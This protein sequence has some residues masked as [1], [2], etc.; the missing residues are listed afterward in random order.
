MDERLERDLRVGLA[1]I[2]DPV[3]ESHPRWATSPAAERVLGVPAHRGLAGRFGLLWAAV[4]AGLLLVALLAAAFVGGWRPDLAIV[5]APSPLPATVT[6]VIDKAADVLATTKARPLPAQATCPPGSNPD[7]LGS[8]DQDR[9][10]GGAMAFD[11]HAGRIVVYDGSQTWTYDVCTNTWKRMGAAGGPVLAED[12]PLVYDADSDRVLAFGRDQQGSL[13]APSAA[14]SVAP[15]TEVAASA[16]PANGDLPEATAGDEEA[17]AATDEEQGDGQSAGP[18]TGTRV[19]WSLDLAAGRWT[20]VGSFPWAKS[21]TANPTYGTTFYHDPSGLVVVYDGATMWAYDVDTNTLAKVHQRPDASVPADAGLPDGMIAFGY[22][23]GHDRV[24]AVVV[25]RA[26]QRP[27]ANLGMGVPTSPSAE[28]WIFDPATGSWHLEAAA[29]ASDLI[30]C[31]YGRASTDCW[32]T[33][34]RAVFDEASGLAVFFNRDNGGAATA[35][36]TP[37]RIDAYDV[38]RRAWRTL[39]DPVE[40]GATP[41]W[42]ESM[43]PVYDPLNR[44]IVCLSSA[45][46]PMGESSWSAPYAGVWAFSTATGQSRWLLEPDTARR[47]DVSTLAGKP[48]E[49]GAADGSGAAARFSEPRS[50]VMDAAGTFYITDTGNHTIR[51]MTPDGIVTTFVGRLGESGSAD[52][53]AG[54]ARFNRP[55][56]VAIDEAGVLYVA[57]TENDAIRRVAPDGTV[58]TLAQRL[59]ISPVG[60]AVNGGGWAGY[61]PSVYAGGREGNVILQIALDGTV[62][63]LAGERDRPGFADGTGPAARFAS[64]TSLEFAGWGDLYVIDVASRGDH[65]EL[66][67]VSPSGSSSYGT[68][69]T[70]EGDWESYGQPGA[71]WADPSGSLDVSSSLDNTILETGMGAGS[72]T[73]LAGVPGEAGYRDGRRDLARFRGPTDI[74]RDATGLFYVVDSGNSVIRTMACTP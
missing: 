26:D 54:E 70:P 24:V 64:P 53:T 43:P 59:G 4:L 56:G 61:P 3:V 33:Q 47:C 41:N 68:V 69:S 38:G 10:T 45:D 12:A 19:V 66:R 42:C 36:A 2:L 71:V 30:V 51:K 49:A 62:T 21:D 34:G 31:S 15:E 25:Q 35:L 17:T 65:S 32:P 57:D 5:I 67:I 55:G 72:V 48:G 11:R 58:T 18:S 39:R 7:A 22:D 27:D 28:T 29:A 46:E 40:G 14:P 8:V 23:P 52:G 73:L 60:I 20:K 16:A 1:E 9:P 63:T 6:T 50:I 44:R 74:V 37:G 13:A